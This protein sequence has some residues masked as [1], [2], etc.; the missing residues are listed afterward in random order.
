MARLFR[1]RLWLLVTLAFLGLIAA[2]TALIVV[3]QRHR[4]EPVPIVR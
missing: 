3:A 1:N 4:P 2:W